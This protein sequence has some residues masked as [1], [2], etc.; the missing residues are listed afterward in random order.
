[1]FFVKFTYKIC[2][3]GFGTRS[4]KRCKHTHTD[5]AISVHL[6]VCPYLST[7]KLLLGWLSWYFIFINFLKV[8]DMYS[9]FG[10]YCTKVIHICSEDKQVCLHPF[11]CK[12]VTIGP[13][14]LLLVDTIEKVNPYIWCQVLFSLKSCSF[15]EY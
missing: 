4:A 3:D 15:R 10:Y 7:L 5:L 2:A 12:E 6:K 11:E 8:I 14:K 1:M 13:K 9:Y